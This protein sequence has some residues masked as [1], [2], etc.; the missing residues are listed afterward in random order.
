MRLLLLLLAVQWSVIWAGA[1]VIVLL[2]A[3]D[4]NTVMSLPPVGLPIVERIDVTAPV[5]APAVVGVR[6]IVVPLGLTCDSITIDVPLGRQWPGFTG[7]RRDPT[8]SHFYRWVPPYNLIAGSWDFAKLVRARDALFPLTHGQHVDTAWT[9]VTPVNGTWNPPRATG[10]YRF[11]LQ[12][13]SSWLG[14]VRYGLGMYLE[15]V[16]VSPPPP[17]HT[18]A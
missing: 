9:L 3:L 18:L 6:D 15:L 10:L 1:P 8:R 16:R 4:P 17:H 2:E 13:N 7:M 12:V 11:T 14:G 5:P